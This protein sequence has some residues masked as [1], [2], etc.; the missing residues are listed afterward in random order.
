MPPC[1]GTFGAFK[2]PRP[3][4]VQAKSSDKKAVFSLS[5]VV[6]PRGNDVVMEH[7]VHSRTDLETGAAAWNLEASRVYTLALMTDRA[8]T[9][10]TVIEVGG[11]PIVQSKCSSSGPG[12]AGIWT[13]PTRR[14]DS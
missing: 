10:D 1:T 11:K 2:A 14:V 3:I 5:V 13:V 6:Q 7:W 12:V 9:I 4:R 8:L